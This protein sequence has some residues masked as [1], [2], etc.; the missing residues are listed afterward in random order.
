VFVG[1]VNGQV[2]SLQIPHPSH[3]PSLPLFLPISTHTPT[4]PSIADLMAGD[5]CSGDCKVLTSV[6]CT[7]LPADECKKD[8][9]LQKEADK[10][11]SCLADADGELQDALLDC[12]YAEKVTPRY[13]PITTRHILTDDV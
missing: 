2:S 5:S 13:V 3:P 11:L 10:A 4:G 12:V 1:M 7:S 9:G 6:Q 8:N